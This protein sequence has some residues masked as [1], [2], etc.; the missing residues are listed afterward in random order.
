MPS[1]PSRAQ[2]VQ[3]ISHSHSFWPVVPEEEGTSYIHTLYHLHAASL[4]RECTVH[5][6]LKKKVWD[7]L[8]RAEHA[9]V[10]QSCVWLCR[11]ENHA[12]IKM[13]KEVDDHVVYRWPNVWSNE[14][15]IIWS[16]WN[17]MEG[18]LISI[19]NV[20]FMEKDSAQRD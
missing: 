18:Q 7:Y 16:I 12:S 5:G 14:I 10:R 6:G 8:A 19:K 20:D 13:P 17:Y 1:N 4:F 9:S 15:F 3:A 2:F 11:K